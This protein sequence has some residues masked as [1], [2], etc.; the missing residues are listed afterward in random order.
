MKRISIT[1]LIFF[2]FCLNSLET[3]SQTY[4]RICVI[5]SST[6]WGYFNGMYPRDSGYAFKLSKYYKSLNLIDTLYNI[7]VNGSDPYFGMPSS[8]SPPAGRDAPDGRYNI[9]RAV[10]FVPKPDVII[11]NY[12][13]N[14]YDYFTTSE[15]LFCLQTIKDSANAK[16][17]VCYITTTQPR[18]NF[19]AGER[20]NLLVLRDS[21][22]NR[23]GEF[24]I[25]FYDPIVQNPEMIIKP[26]YSLG[27][28]VHTNPAGQTVLENVVI[29]KNILFSVL[30]LNFIA[31]SGH[32]KANGI[33]IEWSV[34]SVINTSYFSIERSND[35]I[36]FV[37]IGDINFSVGK[38]N[39][40][41]NDLNATQGKFY[42]RIVGISPDNKKTI[43]NIIS[44]TNNNP[45][46]F[47]NIFFNHDT[48]E[49]HLHFEQNN[50][51]NPTLLFIFDL[52]GKTVFK[53]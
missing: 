51:A 1:L 8:Y 44:V 29:N 20:E 26:E 32:T 38:I 30:P 14:H 15:V 13:S 27:D 28:G 3:Q 49:L 24:A 22:L 42:Y 10:N 18:D 43:S 16:G 17:I 39:Y 33:E 36:N 48:Q 19:N 50:L 21:I 45:G 52:S 47:A 7:A 37:H 25:N 53:K 23:F 12:P 4:K 5:G 41:F 34:N 11:V 35:G 46:S 40:N 6:S 31:M 9:T 2:Y